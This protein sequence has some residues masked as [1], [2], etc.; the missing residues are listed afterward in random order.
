MSCPESEWVDFRYHH[1]EVLEAEI[2]R[3][4]ERLELFFAQ[5]LSGA[6]FMMIDEPIEWNDSTN[7]AE[8]LDY[9]CK[10]QRMTRVNQAMLD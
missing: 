4:Q 6:F 1:T 10:H 3:Q 2:A 8:V 5:S 7:K 9:V